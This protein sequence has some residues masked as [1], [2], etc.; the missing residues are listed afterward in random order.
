MPRPERLRA[1]NTFVLDPVI[2]CRCGNRAKVFLEIHAVDLCTAEHPTRCSFL[3]KSCLKRDV[4]RAELVALDGAE[5]CSS[6][7]RTIVRLSDIIVRICSLE[8]EELS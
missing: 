3:C 4:K 7:G 5:W 2:K 8:R 6:C 1:G